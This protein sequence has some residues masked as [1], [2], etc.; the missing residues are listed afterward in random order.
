M[1]SLPLP[2]LLFLPAF[3]LLNLLFKIYS[4]LRSPLRPIPGPWHTH[5]SSLRLKYAIITGTR[6]D[7][8][9]SLHQT[10]GPFVRISPTE[11]AVSDPQATKEIHRIGGGYVK[12]GMYENMR[13]GAPDGPQGVFTMVNSRE[14]AARRRLLA[15]GFSV[16]ALRERWEGTVRERVRLAV[17]RMREETRDRGRAD[18]LKWWLFMATDVSAH[19]MFGDSFHMLEKGEKVDYILAI[20]R[21]MLG[22]ALLTELPMVWRIGRLIPLPS[23]RAIFHN[24]AILLSQGKQAMRTVKSTQHAANIFDQIVAEAEKGDETLT[25]EEVVSE[26]ANLILAGTDT[27]ANTATY[28][29]WALLKHP[30]ALKALRAELKTVEEP[31][32]D[33]KLEKLPVLNACIEESLR[34]YGAAP[35]SEPR[36][37]PAGGARLGEF[38]FP[39]GST[40]STQA[41]TAHRRPEVFTDPEKFDVFRWLDGR[42]TDA[43]RH[44]MAPFGHG[45]RVCLG[46]HLA[47]MELR[48]A[49]AEFFGKCDAE[50]AKE[51]TGESMSVV[52]HFLIA[53]KA[54]KCE[55]IVR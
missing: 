25:E 31:F 41:W 6:T 9:H 45:A 12:A 18:V 23:F 54:G 36:T 3:L 24:S 8:I 48:L 32:T 30:A 52:N 42:P 14:H 4:A 17:G 13:T 35:S 21:A 16:G 10:Y 19:V 47:K 5:L 38:F 53:P 37:V 28:M 27:T 29:T 20:E 2:L 50:I 39:E 26:A 15:R 40:V 7:W 1:L 51:T 33:A 22:T 55:I 43:M 44:T 11:T 34:L 49:A 46:V